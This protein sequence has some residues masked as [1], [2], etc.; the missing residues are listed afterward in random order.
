[1]QRQCHK[2]P[3]TS[4]ILGALYPLCSL[5]TD[6]PSL[7]RQGRLALPHPGIPKATEGCLVPGAPGEGAPRAVPS[8]GRRQPGELQPRPPTFLGALSFQVRLQVQS[9]ERPQ[10]RGTLHCFQSIVKQESVSGLGLGGGGRGGG[11]WPWDTG[12]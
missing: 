2:K 11:G 9:M 6:T 3:G 10:Y 8:A 7:K 12:L 4:E 1:M 5:P